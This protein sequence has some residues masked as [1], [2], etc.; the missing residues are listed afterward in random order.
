MILSNVK[1]FV[2]KFLIIL[3]IVSQFAFVATYLLTP[4]PA[5]AFW[6][7]A[8][9]AF[10]YVMVNIPQVVE[11]VAMGILE[12]IA[13][14][15]A[16]KYLTR[17]VQ[18][19]S[20]KY[21]IGDFLNY[22][23]YLSNYYLTN[24]ILRNVQDPNLRRAYQLMI[25]VSLTGDTQGTTGT[26]PRKALIPQLKAAM[27]QYYTDHGGIDP[28]KIYYPAANITDRQYFAMAQ[29]YYANPPSFT[30]QNLRGQFGALQSEATTAAQLEVS[31]GNGLKAGRVIGGFCSNQTDNASWGNTNAGKGWDPVSCAAAGGKWNASALDIAK[32]FINNPA[33]TISNY[34]DKGIDSIFKGN[35]DP[36]N[37]FVQIGQALGDF[38]FTKLD[39]NSTG[40]TLG[41]DGYD[42]NQYSSNNPASLKTIDIDGDGIPDVQDNDKNGIVSVGD[43]CYFGLVDPNQDPTKPPVCIPSSDPRAGGSNYFTPFCKSVDDAV[44]EMKAW[45]DFQQKHISQIQGSPTTLDNIFGVLFGHQ[46]QTDFTHNEDAQL[47]G[48]EGSRAASAISNLIQ[49]IRSL[50]STRPGVDDIIVQLNRYYVWQGEINERLMGHADTDLGHNRGGFINLAKY[51]SEIRDYVERIRATLVNCTKPDITAVTPPVVP[52]DVNT[53]NSGTTNPPCTSKGQAEQ[54]FI[55]PLL[56]AVTS[57]NPVT[58]PPSQTYINSIENIVNMTNSEFSLVTGS[59]AAYYKASN[60]VSLPEFHAYGPLPTRLLSP[61]TGLPWDITVLCVP[62]GTNPSPTPSP[63]PAP[64]PT[65]TP[66]PP[67]TFSLV[68]AITGS[69]TVTDGTDSCVSTSTLSCTKNYP[70]NTN[71][72]LKATPATGKTFAGWGGD[73]VSFNTNPVCTGIMSVNRNVTAKFQ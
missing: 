2:F 12:R 51:S 53:P 63:T 39:L 52:P 43:V 34:I 22:D 70:P 68:V 28:N 35:F 31:V 38:L 40:S 56:N 6:G 17:F 48:E 18:Q 11:K 7:A 60:S 29:S 26:D 16:N 46:D 45:V 19:V 69:G 71:V 44:D 32:S 37:I 1:L 8:D 33:A 50:N 55:L 49:G 13:V 41:N 21:R 24:A 27:A 3:L 47:W 10:S 59:S 25:G 4:K 58:S 61:S 15:Y 20:D 9:Q 64:A 66:T 14:N 36:T 67:S 54:S 57:D 23:K 62:P 73:C 42:P 5:E 65:P 30:E 72:T